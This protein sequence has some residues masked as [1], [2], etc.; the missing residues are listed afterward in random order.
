[1]TTLDFTVELFV[2]VD[3]A[4]PALPKHP[5]SKLHPSEVVTIG[6]LYALRGGSFRHFYRFL[7]RDLASLFPRLPERTRLHRLLCRA[8]EH[9]RHFL[10]LPS[11][12]ALLLGRVGRLWHRVVAPAPRRMD[13]DAVGAH[14]QKQRALDRGRQDGAVHQRVGSSGQL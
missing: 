8:K 13:K 7:G 2:R 10:A 5:L 12:S 6:L 9:T 3:E 4:L 14:R 11:F 1:M